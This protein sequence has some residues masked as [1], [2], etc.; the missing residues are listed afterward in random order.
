MNDEVS[1]YIAQMSRWQDEF[2]SMRTILLDCGLEE[3]IKW[4]TPCYMYKGK[5][6][7]LLGQFKEDCVLSFVKGAL[8]S[9][10]HKLLQKPGENSRHGMVLR[11]TDVEQIHSLKP[12][13]RQCVYEAIEVEKAGLKIE[14]PPVP[15][16][17]YPAELLAAL[18]ADTALKSAFEALTPGRQRG[19]ILHF[20]GAKQSATRVKRIEAAKS[21]IMQ[22]KGIHDCICGHSKRMPRCDGSHKH[23]V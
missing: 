2:M 14:T 4:R 7:A 8:L 23:H 16:E 20:N 11:F 21:R 13:I 12:I 5:N 6:V 3:T 1:Q 17:S 19:L 15:S 22:G 18:N 10:E 9:N